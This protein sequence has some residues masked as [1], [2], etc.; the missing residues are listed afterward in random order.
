MITFTKAGDETPSS[1]DHYLSVEINSNN[2][3]ACLNFSSRLAMYDFARSLLQ[4][5]IY[6]TVGEIEFYP[7]EFQGKLE[8]INGTR[9]SL[10]SARMF[11]FYQKESISP[12]K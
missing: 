4:E 12:T 1:E 7:L 2:Q 11:V 6:G 10:D 3:Y 8:V 5:S 9:M